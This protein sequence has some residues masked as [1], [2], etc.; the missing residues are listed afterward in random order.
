[1]PGVLYQC[2]TCGARVRARQ[3]RAHLGGVH[4]VDGDG[5]R[6]L[7]PTGGNTYCRLSHVPSCRSYT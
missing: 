5:I 2:K 7:G 6:L 4:H 1:M 3:R